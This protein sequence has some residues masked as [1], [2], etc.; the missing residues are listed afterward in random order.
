MEIKNYPL[1]LQNIIACLSIDP[2]YKNGFKVK[3]QIEKL[4][5]R[6]K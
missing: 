3:D 5:N 4:L 1:A 2:N 6:D